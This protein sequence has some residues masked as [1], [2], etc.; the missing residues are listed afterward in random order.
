MWLTAVTENKL[1]PVV[2]KSVTSCASDP[3]QYNRAYVNLYSGLYKSYRK[4][5]HC[6]KAVA[7]RTANSVCAQ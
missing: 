6:P 7:S 4:M 5:R 3:L 1:Y 2:R